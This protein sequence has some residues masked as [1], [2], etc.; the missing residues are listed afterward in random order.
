MNGFEPLGTEPDCRTVAAFDIMTM[1]LRLSLFELDITLLISYLTE[2]L[3]FAR[4]IR[5]DSSLSQYR[6]SS[7]EAMDVPDWQECSRLQPQSGALPL[8]DV[9]PKPVTIT[10]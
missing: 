9:R 10:G 3:S 7:S 2:S 8:S 1:N 6:S 4:D 5:L